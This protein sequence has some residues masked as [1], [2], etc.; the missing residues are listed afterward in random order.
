M[1]IFILFFLFTGA[2]NAQAEDFYIYKVKSVIDGDT[3]ELDVSNESLIIQKLGLK[4][5]ILG[6]DSP[7]K[8]GKCKKEKDLSLKSKKL[9]ENLIGKN[10]I[11][12]S[13]IKWDKYG[14]R[15]D[16]K[17]LVNNVDIAQEQ[18]KKGLAVAYFGDRKNN[19]WC[20]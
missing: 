5:R 17:V 19:N 4:V 12:L 7:E 13:N 11:I 1:I 14:G 15:L 20:D 18:L 6:I 2:V 8:N 10:E 9:T 3:I 16:A